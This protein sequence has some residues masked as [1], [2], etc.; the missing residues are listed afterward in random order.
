M[1]VTAGKLVQLGEVRSG[2]SYLSQ[3]DLALHFGLGSAAKVDKVEV[4]WPHGETQVFT[5]VQ[6]DHFYKLKQGAASLTDAGAAA[7]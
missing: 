3:N 5:G 4:M 2:G 6:A 7:K 1:R